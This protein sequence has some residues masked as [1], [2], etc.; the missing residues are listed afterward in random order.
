MMSCYILLLRWKDMT[1]L[2]RAFWNSRSEDKPVFCFRHMHCVYMVHVL[3]MYMTGVNCFK[4]LILKCLK[5]HTDILRVFQ[6]C[7]FLCI[8][9]HWQKNLD[10]KYSFYIYLY[11][12]TC[13]CKVFKNS[14]CFLQVAFL[15]FE[16]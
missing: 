9:D 13:I 4:P 7:S 14:T 3:H 16:F 12:Y 1:N 8:N 11:I 10:G 6:P 5:K 15:K 2:W